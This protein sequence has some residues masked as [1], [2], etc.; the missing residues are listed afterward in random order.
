[1]ITQK[2]SV[3]VPD[4]PWPFPGQV[5][6][7]TS[8]FIDIETTGLKASTS[9]LY[10]IGVLYA[11]GEGWNTIQWM[12]ETSAEEEGLLRV[13]AAFIRPYRALIHFNGERFDLPYLRE[14]YAAH[15]LPCPLD[16]LLS[17]DLYRSIRPLKTLLGLK[18][19][20]QKALEQFLNL[21]REDP[22]TGGELIGVYRQWQH[23][24]SPEDL[25]ALMLH[26][27]EDLTGM[28]PLIS[29]LTCLPLTQVGMADPETGGTD[30]CIRQISCIHT[31]SNVSEPLRLPAVPAD[32][33]P[34]RADDLEC[35]DRFTI[36]LM[37][38]DQVPVSVHRQGELSTLTVTG[39]QAQLLVPVLQ[40]RLRYFFE[41]YRDYYYLPLEDQAIHKSVAVYVDSAHRVK[42]TRQNCYI[43]KE[44]LFLPQKK[45]GGFLPAYR[46][47][48]Q[49]PIRFLEL[50]QTLFSDEPDNVFLRQYT[51]MLLEEHVG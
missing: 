46:R 29:L 47:T 24:R 5:R 27:R 41:N 40:G 23:A 11:T 13:L 18:H 51:A 45:D 22:F 33:L 17:L 10:M 14:K 16:A 31:Q 20:N 32:A 48:W 50:P 1:M 39:T 37:L 44:A 4:L 25:Q 43:P 19:L 49:D 35:I 9:R 12:A 26:N 21:T 2:H 30:P 38:P 42:A 36:R 15:Q 6:P 28:L 7:E 34:S 3:G 8:V